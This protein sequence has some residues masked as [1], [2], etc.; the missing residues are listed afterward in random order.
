MRS[1]LV[2]YSDDGTEWT[3]CFN[4]H[5]IPEWADLERRAYVI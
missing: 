5:R 2:Q 3:T 1:F 4:S